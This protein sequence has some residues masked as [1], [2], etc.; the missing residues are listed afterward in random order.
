[1]YEQLREN[2]IPVVKTSGNVEL[3]AAI[4]ESASPQLKMQPRTII[5]PSLGSIGNL[6][7]IR[8]SDVSSSL[9]SKHFISI[10]IE[11]QT[12]IS[13]MPDVPYL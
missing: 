2:I 3:L 12:V 13:F 10:L 8:P 6:A 11:V 9:E 1:M 4:V 5:L 7:K